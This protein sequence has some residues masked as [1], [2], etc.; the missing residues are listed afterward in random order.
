MRLLFVCAHWHGL[1][2]LRMHTDI[3]LDIADEATTT[4]GASFRDFQAK[5]CSAYITREL[6]REEGARK[7]R[8]SKS[9]TKPQANSKSG[10][11]DGR[12]KKTFNL[13]TYKL[14][15]LGDY[16]ETI[17]RYGTTDSYSTEQVSPMP[18]LHTII[19]QQWQGELEHRS[20]K[21]RYRR[22]DR[23]SFIKQLTQI[24]RRQARIRRIKQ[25]CRQN[26]NERVAN[27]PEAHHHIG[28]SENQF[29][30]IGTFLNAHAGDPA[31]KVGGD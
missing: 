2:K 11:N 22:T 16:V 25:K 29:E 12:M 6:R 1:V 19:Q 20:P 27:T 24:E 5:V 18:L 15:A 8:Q 4:L 10:G 14:H 3:T 13:Q 30:H 23:R 21:A 9:N 7:R 26:R 31:V 28:R 17:R